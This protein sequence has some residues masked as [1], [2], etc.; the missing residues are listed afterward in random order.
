MA[1]MPC[2]KIQAPTCCGCISRILLSCPHPICLTNKIQLMLSVLD[3]ERGHGDKLRKGGPAGNQ[4]TMLH[5]SRFWK[6]EQ[7]MGWSTQKLLTYDT[8]MKHCMVPNFTRQLL[9]LIKMIWLSPPRN[10]FS[11]ARFI[12]QHDSGISLP[13]RLQ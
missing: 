11:R 2:V 7:S 1:H 9:K 4:D 6:A 5:T 3:R 8:L 13:N 10:K 12:M